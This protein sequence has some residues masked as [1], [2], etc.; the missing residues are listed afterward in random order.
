MQ[1]PKILWV[2]VFY[3]AITFV[4][5]AV[6]APLYAWYVGFD[7]VQIVVAILLLGYAGMSITMGYHRLWSHR[8]F[9]SRG[10]LRR[11]CV[12]RADGSPW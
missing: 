4:L 1:K 8:T 9:E 2:N 5:S 7:L 11:S 12:T 10:V 6:A 3:F